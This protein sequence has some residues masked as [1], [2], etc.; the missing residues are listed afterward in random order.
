MRD[1]VMGTKWVVAAVLALAVSSAAAE[2]KGAG[3]SFAA[4]LY[5]TWSQAI[6]KTGESRVDYDSVG[7]G[8]GVKAAQ[9][10]SVDFGASDRP[11]SRG[12]LEQAGLVQFPTA[13][14][15][16]VLIANIP[17][18]PS[19]KI[20][21]DGETLAGIYLGKITQWNDPKLKAL[22]PELSLPALAIVPMFRA[23]NSGT[24]FAFTNYLSKLSPQFKTAIGPTSSLTLVGGK[25]GKTSTDIARVMRETAGSI[26]YFDYSFAVDLSLPTMQIK[27]QWGKFVSASSESLQLAMRAADWE[28][29]L[30][31]QDPTFEMDLTDTGCPGC[32]PIATATYVLVPL[33]GRNGSSA[34]V[35][36]FFDESLQRGDEV[37]VKEGYVPLPTR[38]KNIVSLSMRR[39]QASADKGGSTKVQRH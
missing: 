1:A 37:A 32:W 19:D 36:E 3:S 4:N 35:F 21:L 39:W 10:R 30:I 29:L 18:I 12:V 9:E 20:K 23:E 27:N 34:R 8:A 38:A 7:S 16:V 25:S 14:G 28:K 26:A 33:K 2:I 15:G 31:D 17:G 11:L 6:A 22:N 5:R 13:I 24:S